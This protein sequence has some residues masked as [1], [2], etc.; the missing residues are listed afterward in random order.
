M[1]V[2]QFVKEVSIAFFITI[3]TEIGYWPYAS[4]NQD[5]KNRAKIIWSR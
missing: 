1:T 2:L 5:N 3:R 4:G